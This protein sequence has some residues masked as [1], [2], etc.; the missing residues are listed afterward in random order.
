MGRS[1]WAGG[2]EGQSQLLIE[3]WRAEIRTRGGSG[4]RAERRDLRFRRDRGV[5]RG[6][7]GFLASPY[8]RGALAGG[9]EPARGARVVLLRTPKVGAIIGGVRAALAWRGRGVVEVERREDHRNKIRDED[10]GEATGAF[11]VQSSGSS[12]LAGR[13]VV[14]SQGDAASPLPPGASSPRA[15]S[16]SCSAACAGCSHTNEW[17]SHT[18]EWGLDSLSQMTGSPLKFEK[19]PPTLMLDGMVCVLHTV[20]SIMAS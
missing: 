1:W 13:R 7:Q 19:W 17:G 8:R 20:Y 2:A 3:G 5:V 11:A 14:S 10:G 18:N 16:P 4:G 6:D 12:K 15:A 9:R